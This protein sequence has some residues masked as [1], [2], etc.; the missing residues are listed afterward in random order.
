MLA[1][2]SRLANARKSFAVE[3]TL[4][5]RTYFR[6]LRRW[7]SDGYRIEIVFLALPSVNLALQ[8]IAARVRQGGHDVARSDVMRRFQRSWDN[9]QKLY[10]PLAD[11][12]AVYDNS[13]RLP[14]LIMEFP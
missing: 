14:R 6:L 12:W 5:G 4:S 1:E 7:K 2:L 9:F 3:S 8:R 13:G 10:S 11:T